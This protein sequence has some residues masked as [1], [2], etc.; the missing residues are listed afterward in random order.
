M[1]REAILL[2]KSLVRRP[3]I[4]NDIDVDLEHDFIAFWD[5]AKIGERCSLEKRQNTV[6]INRSSN[7]HDDFQEWCRKVV[8]WG[9]KRGAYLYP[10]QSKTIEL[11]LAG[12]Y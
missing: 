7:R 12:H 4:E 6:Q 3:F 5:S 11:Q 1:L 9:N 10:N 2:N 8:W